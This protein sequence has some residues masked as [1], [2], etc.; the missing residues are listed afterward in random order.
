MIAL[1]YVLSM[2]A[3]VVLMIAIAVVVAIKDDD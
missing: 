2:I 1:W 3:I